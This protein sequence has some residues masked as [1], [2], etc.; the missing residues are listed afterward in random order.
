MAYI[1][2]QPGRHILTEDITCSQLIFDAPDITLD[3]TGRM[4]TF[5]DVPES[6]LYRDKVCVIFNYG[7][8][9]LVSSDLTARAGILNATGSRVMFDYSL[10]PAVYFSMVVNPV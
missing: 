5:T 6:T 3:I 2:N 8:C 1:I 9:S 10:Y 4:I 7:N